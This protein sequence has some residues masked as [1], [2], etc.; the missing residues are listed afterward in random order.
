MSSFLLALQFLTI[1]T[2]R[3]NLAAGPGDLARS[4]AWFGLVGALLGW[5]LAGLA[6]LLARVLPPLA[7]AGVMVFFWAACTRFLHLD[8]VADTADAL[9]HT[10]S[11]T[12]ALQIM[13][14]TRL[15]SFGVAAICGLLLVKFAAL[16]SLIPARLYLALALAPPLARALAAGLSVTLPPAR[17]NQ[18]LGAASART[19]RPDQGAA[20]LLAAGLSALAAA[21]LAGAL[22]QGP[23]GLLAALAAALGVLALGVI[24]G[25][26]FRR[27][28][29]GVTGDCLGAAIES[30]ELVAL[31]MLC[32][33]S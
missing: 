2:L 28:L 24:L 7:L 17:V 30:G 6:W 21:C 19:Q 27:R 1:A 26:W 20:A 11:K 3:P 18:G 13:K 33:W 4:R 16:A 31:L 5:F 9:V 29:G 23:R 32:A 8:G 15:G 14:D 10:T 12:R 22:L 25:L